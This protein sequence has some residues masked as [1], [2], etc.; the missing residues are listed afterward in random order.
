MTFWN[1]IGRDEAGLSTEQ[2]QVV[3]CHLVNLPFGLLAILSTSKK[4]DKEKGEVRV[5]SLVCLG[6]DK[7]RLTGQNLGRVFNYRG[8]HVWSMHSSAY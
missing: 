6:M 8:G 1:L 4:N 5:V 7:L 2:V 3:P